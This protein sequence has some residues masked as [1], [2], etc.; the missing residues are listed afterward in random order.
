MKIKRFKL[1][2]TI[3]R[4]ASWNALFVIAL[5]IVLNT[6]F[7][8]ILKYEA[9]RIKDDYLEH[10]LEHLLFTMHVENDSLIIDH[11][12]ELQETDLITVRPTSFFLQVYSPEKDIFLQSNN[13]TEFGHIPL[14][15]PAYRDSI[16]F[17]NIDLGQH[18]LRTVYTYLTNE[19][20]EPA[21]IVQLS[22]FKTNLSQ[23]MPLLFQ[24]NL[25]SFPFIILLIIVVSIILARRSF[26]PIN[27]IINLA[28]RI[29]ATHLNQRLDYKARPDDELG[30][31]RDTLNNLFDR[32]EFQFNRISQFTDNASHQLMSPLTVLK[33]ELEY[34][35]R[36]SHDN[37]ECREAFSVM[38]QQTDRMIK[39]VRTL[40]ILA[41]ECD[42]CHNDQSIFNLSKVVFGMEIVFPNQHLELD[43]ENGLY[44]R[45][46]SEY[47]SMVMQNLI[48]NAIKYSDASESVT[49]TAKLHNQTIYIDV[50]DH[51]IGIPDDQRE[52]IFERFYR[53]E[54]NR[55]NQIAGF[56]LGLS[57]VKS[58][59]NAMNGSVQ[60]YDNKPTGACFRITLPALSVE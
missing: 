44:V 33:S 14:R 39:I 27:K 10:E 53:F 32:L 55:N 3:I 58:I 51:G 1:S 19:R 30:R 38:S 6:F 29:S 28:N 13:L 22:A 45:G 21:A 56:G 11:K 8:L 23:F 18:T 12:R 54:N 26:A 43:V 47:F 4:N 40:L 46:N 15:I 42:D 16:R 20:G 37:K 48:D 2:G 17:T 49:V 50:C 52:R 7:L 25:Y 34:I 35:Q 36:K 57:L 24:Y 60:I 59:V 31:L 41:K 5:Y 9:S